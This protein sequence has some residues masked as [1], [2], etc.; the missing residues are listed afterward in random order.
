M[1]IV[2]ALT[3]LS[4]LAELVGPSLLHMFLPRP[5]PGTNF[6]A[7]SDGM[8]I[9]LWRKEAE[10]RHERRAAAYLRLKSSKRSAANVENG[11]AV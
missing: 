10:Y 5:C 6:R 9:R 4:L 7:P 11:F 1:L 2:I 8:Q 3:A